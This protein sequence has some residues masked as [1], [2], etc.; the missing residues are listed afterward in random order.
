MTNRPAPALLKWP[1]ILADV[2]LLIA[3][4][5]VITIAL[6]AKAYSI[7][8][9]AIVGWMFGAWI[10]VLPWLK[11]FQAECKLSES[12]NLTSALEQ[13][14]K[15]EEIGARVQAATGTWQSAQDAATRVTASAKEIEEKIRA[16]AK[17][18]MEFAER[19]NNDEKQHLRLEVEKLRRNE[20]EWLQV[21]ARMLDHTF[22][23]TVAAH[24][25]GQPNL[26]AQMNNF[27]NACRDAARRVGLVPFHPN[28]GDAYDDRSQQLED[29]N[30]KPE[31]G[32]VVSDILATG[33]TFQGQL[34]R[35]ALVR[36]SGAQQPQTDQPQ[37]EE[38][39]APAPEPIA[40]EQQIAVAEQAEETHQQHEHEQ[41]AEPSNQWDR[42]EQSFEQKNESETKAVV[43][44]EQNVPVFADSSS[45]EEKH[46][47]DSHTTHESVEEKPVAQSNYDYPDADSFNEREHD[48]SAAETSSS[49]EGEGL[50]DDS[51]HS[52]HSH[53]QPVE[54]ASPEH[55]TD[56]PTAD[57]TEKP[58]RRQ[59]K[60]DPQTSLP[61]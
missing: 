14:K 49:L 3:C 26:A 27:Q 51:N 1:F 39:A 55:P 56:Q 16:D 30:A 36:I 19:I 29:A 47:T 5:W 35:K 38:Q 53:A 50:S 52:D 4:A 23:I 11:E 25:S 22:A 6:P 48:N 10:C 20:G 33:Y 44:A 9:V 17:E 41:P 61:F 37:Q 57:E 43:A 8:A 13:I 24:R 12:E 45:A 15:L 2:A 7:V 31:D 18:F 21:A 28:A 58:R 34:L 32:A 46:L 59:R 40:T 54:I 60:P 42:L